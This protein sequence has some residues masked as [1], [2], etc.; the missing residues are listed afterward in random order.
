MTFSPC[1]YL[2]IRILHLKIKNCIL[3]R[4]GGIGRHAS[5]RNWWGKTRGGS[6]PLLGTKTK[7]T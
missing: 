2:T 7:L 6:S 3:G 5:L 1:K 4:D